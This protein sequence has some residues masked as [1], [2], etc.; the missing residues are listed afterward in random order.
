MT[1]T[2]VILSVVWLERSDESMV[3]YNRVLESCQLNEYTGTSI[4]H[5][6]S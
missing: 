3:K 2:I 6:Y 5:L 4:K 1:D